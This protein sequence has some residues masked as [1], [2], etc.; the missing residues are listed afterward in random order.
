MFIYLLRLHIQ[1]AGPIS[2]K[3]GMN[4][5]DTFYYHLGFV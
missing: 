5:A 4:V 1:T 2:M 3:F